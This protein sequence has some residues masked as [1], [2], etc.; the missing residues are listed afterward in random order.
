[1]LRSGDSSTWLWS[2]WWQALSSPLGI[3]CAVLL[4]VLVIAGA[5][6]VRLGVRLGNAAG[7]GDAERSGVLADERGTATIEF[8]LILPV[9]LTVALLLV[10]TTLVM[11]GNIFVHYSAFAAVRSAV[12]QIPAAYEGEPANWYVDDR[13][14]VK[15][16]AIH[17]AAAMALL[18]VAGP[19][20]SAGE[21]AWLSTGVAEG[22]GTM[23]R[24]LGEAEPY[25]VSDRMTGRMSYALE[26]TD[27]QVLRMHGGA[28]ADD[29]GGQGWADESG[30][31]AEQLT[32]GRVSARDAIAV[33]VEHRLH[34]PVPY[35][36]RVFA[37]G[38]TEWGGMTMELGARSML[39]NFGLL[40]R[41]PDEPE[42]ERVP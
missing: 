29:E 13:E 40:D 31:R 4:L 30:V 27:V 32:R 10:Q 25:W 26:H 17:R 2:W 14:A 7:E 42:L 41:L 16:E 23:H 15:R 22:L 9:L 19:R 36:N 18:P 35:V 12:V 6:L 5:V 8:A 34:L 28:T 39:T 33:R 3:T 1:M 21:Q 38:Q 20:G 11:G 24:R 37:D